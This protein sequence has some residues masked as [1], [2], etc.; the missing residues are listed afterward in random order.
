MVTKGGFGSSFIASRFTPGIAVLLD[1]LLSMQR[2]GSWWEQGRWA[3]RQVGS[4]GRR[5]KNLGRESQP[6]RAESVQAPRQV[7]SDGA[8]GVVLASEAP[9]HDGPGPFRRPSQC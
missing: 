4:A 5:R 2:W 9:F 8:C 6:D 7:V 1:D 3:G